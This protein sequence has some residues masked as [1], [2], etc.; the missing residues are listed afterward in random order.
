MRLP[1]ILRDRSAIVLLVALLIAVPLWWWRPA[2][3][4]D[5]SATTTQEMVVARRPFNATMSLVGT[6]VPGDGIYIVG[7]FDGTIATTGFA[8]GDRVTRGQL[9]V[10]VDT[11]D[12]D[13]RLGDAEAAYLK[14]RQ[15][16]D[17][18]ATWS[19][20]QE[21][22]RARRAVAGATYDLA[23]TRRRLTE[24][25][26][27]LDKGLVAR[28][29]YDSLQQQVQSQNLALAAAREDH[30]A[31]L[32]RGAG[33][34]RRLS[35]LALNH[36]EARF[37]ALRAQA[38]AAM[39]RASEGGIVVRPP[40]GKG[41]GAGE[42]RA[43]MQVAMGQL[44][45]TI[46]QPGGLAVSF[47]LDERDVNTIRV[48]QRV[49]VIGA[50]FAGALQGKVTRVAGQ[51]SAATAANK[52]SFVAIARLDPPP[53]DQAA[54]VRIGMTGTVTITTFSKPSAIVVPPAAVIGAAP[55][56][57]VMVKR[58]GATQ[59]VS[60]TIGHVAPDGVEILSGLKVGDT[61]VW[62]S[63]PPPA[64]PGAGT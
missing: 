50:G 27:L 54:S 17:E 3:A 21:A 11:A 37:R 39:V 13:Q 31:V 64:V 35:L 34:N 26:T 30:A 16:D 44:I 32:R 51:A 62:S 10:A 12:L 53:A 52:S 40:A 36:A 46:V 1:D 57:Q 9:L 25:R 29:E 33:D 20:G 23:D 43:G 48:G 2:P 14:A 19:S 22:S 28:S 15:S 5:A 42:V 6:I 45:G 47:N 58:G 61:I 63:T 4:T 8:Y 38:A 24:T 56:A 7:P 59:A 55:A 60:V 18:I 49:T 41:D